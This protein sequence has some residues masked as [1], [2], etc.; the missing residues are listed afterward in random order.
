MTESLASYAFLPWLRRG[1]ATRI[2]RVDGT[3][4]ATPNVELPTSLSLNGGSLNTS[5]PLTLHGPGDVTGLDPRAVIRTWPRPGQAESEPNYFPLVEFGQADLPWRYTPAR[6]TSGDRLRPWLCLIALA[7]DEIDEY[8]AAGPGRPL[9]VVAVKGTALLPKLDQ[10][11]AWAHVQVAGIETVDASTAAELFA[12]QPTRIISRLLCARRLDAATRYRAFV[13]PTFERGRRTGLGEPIDGTVDGLAPAWSDGNA[14]IRLPIYYEWQFQTGSSADFEVL[15]RLLRPR[16][17]PPTVGLREIDVSEPRAG[18][19][20]AF[21]GALGLE[22]ALRA[23]STQSTAWTGTERS[24]FVQALAMLLN[25]GVERLQTAG[26]PR[27][28]VPPLYG[29]RHARRETLG[30]SAQDGPPWLRE[31]NTDPRLRVAAGL[32]TL[33]VQAQQRQLMASAWQQLGDVRRI[34]EEL[35][36]AQLAR[37]AAGRIFDRH[38]AA[39]DPETVLQVTAPLHARVRL[40][41]TTIRTTFQQSPVV[42]GALDGQYRRVA[43][44]LGPLGR[45]Q[46]RPALPRTTTVLGRTN[47]G[48]LAPAP[49]PSTPTAMLTAARA[50]SLSSTGLTPQVRDV[51]A[52]MLGSTALARSATTTVQAKSTPSAIS[53][54]I[55]TL[56][57]RQGFNPAEPLPGGDTPTRPTTPP[58]NAGQVAQDFRLA[59]DSLFGRLGAPPSAPQPLHRARLDQVQSAVLAKLDPRAAIADSLSERLQRPPGT[60]PPADPLEPVMAAPSFAE[61]MYEAL[62]DA[63]QELLLPGL[64]KVQPNTAALLQVNQRFVEA[65]MVGLNHEMARE[66]LWN[67]YPT[68]QRGTYF[69]HFWD[70]GGFLTGDGSETG[71]IPDALADIKPIHTWS[72]TAELGQNSGRDPA[73]SGQLVLLV[74]GELLRRYPNAVV[75]VVRARNAGGRRELTDEELHPIFG[76]KL[77]PDVGFFGFNLTTAQARG[78]STDPGWF[79]VIQEQPT[80]PRFGLDV[81]NGSSGPPRQWNDLSWQH[82]VPPGSEPAA[83]TYVDLTGSLPD[84]SQIVDPENAGAAWHANRG[85]RASDLAY[86]TMQR[87]VRVAIHATDLLPPA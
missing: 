35:R 4:G 34:N 59:L 28:V 22:G 29:G 5:V 52:T 19:P 62:R 65:Y 14:P 38:I 87:P 60:P 61:P 66:L 27:I 83:I 64:D 84:T 30:P 63:S 73:A 80:E 18:L 26:V 25:R 86:I 81:P 58:A 75:Y 74:R 57:S 16:V 41:T 77:D 44:P 1:L 40:G 37:E 46:G 72:G 47:L 36:L 56:P 3:D 8:L 11:W 51:L 49:A 53:E 24:S 33:V 50:T 20:A 76:G 71:A 79:F 68:D 70:T 54:P 43:R 82:L 2:A 78:S 12:D 69:R 45:R 85:S 7:D 21:S 17:L 13:V 15:V 32:G 9:A 6:A 39:G 55:A 67:E 31:L 42:V 48:A 23:L 10:S